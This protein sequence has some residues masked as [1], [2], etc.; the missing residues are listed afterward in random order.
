[1]NKGQWTKDEHKAF[2][3]GWKKYGNNWKDITTIVNMRTAMQV[4][5]HTQYHVQKS[6]PPK[7]KARVLEVNAVGHQRY[8][9]SLPPKKKARIFEANAVGHQQYR[10]SLPPKKKARIFGG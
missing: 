10:E 7:E 2:L 8:Q 6:L 1:M 9:E 4:K 5:R 3:L